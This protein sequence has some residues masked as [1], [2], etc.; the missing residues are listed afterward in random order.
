MKTLKWE[1]K[2][3][4]MQLRW[5]V[6]PYLGVLGVALML[7]KPDTDFNGIDINGLQSL[8][9]GLS[10]YVF[11][12]GIYIAFIH[13]A[14]YV[15]F[16]MRRSYALLEKLNR[17]T[18]TFTALARTAINVLT[19]LLGWAML[20]LA[21]KKLSLGGTIGLSL[22]II[23]V[24]VRLAGSYALSYDPPAILVKSGVVILTVLLLGVSCRLYDHKYEITY[25]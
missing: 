4:V 14:L 24:T 21:L 1:L 12:C 9:M 11:F 17:H 18:F 2:K 10:M 7:P 8:L 6:L 19:V 5:V 25:L 20:M 23:A 13:P 22:V 3:R 16:D 15:I